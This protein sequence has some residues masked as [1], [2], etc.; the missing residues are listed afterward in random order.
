MT[1]LIHK[2]TILQ[3]SYLFYVA[4]TNNNNKNNLYA[5]KH[6]IYQSIK[7]LAYVVYLICLSVTVT[8]NA[9]VTV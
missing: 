8:V 4:L 6:A 1:I 7:F 9:S 3:Q 5:V 2:E